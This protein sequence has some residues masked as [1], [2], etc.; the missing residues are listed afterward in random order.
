MKHETVQYTNH[1][2]RPC[3]VVVIALGFVG[4][5]VAVVC[6]SVRPGATI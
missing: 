1:R 4:V 5:A 2:L 3:A 6:F